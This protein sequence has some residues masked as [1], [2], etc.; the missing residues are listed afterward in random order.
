M[1]LMNQMNEKQ[2]PLLVTEEDLKTFEE[3]SALPGIGQALQRAGLVKIR[4]I[5]HV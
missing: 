2:A 3:E 1:Y 4:E 5:T